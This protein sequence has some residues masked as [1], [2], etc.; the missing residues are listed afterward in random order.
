[1][2]YVQFEINDEPKTYKNQDNKQGSIG[3]AF[4]LVF[5]FSSLLPFAFAFV[6]KS[7]GVFLS[8]CVFAGECLAVRGSGR[9]DKLTSEITIDKLYLRLNSRKLK[10]I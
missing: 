8:L 7:R 9:H 2:K 5:K 10:M 3:F 4:F 6:F 1:M